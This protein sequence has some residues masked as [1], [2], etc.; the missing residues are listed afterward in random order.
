MRF[1]KARLA[2]E[3]FAL[4]ALGRPMRQEFLVLERLTEITAI[5]P[6]ALQGN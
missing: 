3:L 5:I 6:S 2:R 4:A 1:L